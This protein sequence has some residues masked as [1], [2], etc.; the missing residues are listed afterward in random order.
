MNAI[1]IALERDA[2]LLEVRSREAASAMALTIS[3]PKRQ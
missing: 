2:T 3:I 1:V